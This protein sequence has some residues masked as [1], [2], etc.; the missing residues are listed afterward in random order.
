MKLKSR[1]D[2]TVKW[3]SAGSRCSLNRLKMQQYEIFQSVLGIKT[4]DLH[5]TAVQCSSEI[6]SF[7]QNV[8]K[9][10]SLSSLK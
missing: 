6:V 5:S 1:H 3:F 8:N 7:K 10:Q 9:F 2:A 4:H